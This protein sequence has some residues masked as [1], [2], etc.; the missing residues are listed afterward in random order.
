MVAGAERFFIHEL[1]DPRET[2][3]VLCDWIARVQPLL[4]RLTGPHEFSGTAVGQR[5]P[6]RWT[7][8]AALQGEGVVRP[9][10]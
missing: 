9:E 1:I 6:G 3:P 2:R 8:A 4:P 7:A 5:L 10:L